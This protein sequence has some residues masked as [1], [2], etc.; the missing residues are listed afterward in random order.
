M[1]KIMFNHGTRPCMCMEVGITQ[2][3]LILVFLDFNILDFVP[4]LV[5]TH[6]LSLHFLGG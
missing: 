3:V 4:S 1:E 2:W 5:L 6:A